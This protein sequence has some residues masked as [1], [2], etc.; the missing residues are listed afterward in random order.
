MNNFITDSEWAEY[1][2]I[3]NDF[4]NDAFQ[5]SFI[6]LKSIRSLDSN[7]SDDSPLY[8]RI[9]LLGL[10][11]DN[12]FR[13]WPI[14][15]DTLTGQIDKESVLLYINNNYL[16]SIAGGIYINEFKRWKINPGLDK[17][18]YEGV[19]YTAKGDSSSA[20]TKDKTLLHFVVLA[21]DYVNAPNNR[22]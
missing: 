4:H 14:N 9:P 5:N 16:E 21:R 15:S 2:G 18:I 3:I 7:G 12:H 20:Q 1:E 10:F 17:F 8:S 22:Y 13:S 6:W 19:T 11:Q